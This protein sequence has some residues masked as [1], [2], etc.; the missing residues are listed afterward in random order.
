MDDDVRGR[1]LDTLQGRFSGDSTGH[2]L[3]HS[4]RVTANALT[5][6]RAEGG[7]PDIVELA[8]LLH[9]ADDRKLFGDDY[10]DCRFASELMRDCGFPDDTVAEVVRIIQHLSFKGKDTEIP[11][12]LEGRIVQDADML[13]AIGA[14]GIARAFAYGGRKGRAM[15]DPD[16][17]PTMDMDE[18]QYFA[19]KGTTINHFYEKLFLL[20]DMMNTETGKRIAKDRHAFMEEFVRR[21]KEEWNGL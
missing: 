5:I 15:Y 4:M 9:D 17:P 6:C 21:F 16:I 8:A 12:S 1:I 18:S 2:G 14:I 19:N 10:R 20:K 7:D 13:D 11:D 3:D